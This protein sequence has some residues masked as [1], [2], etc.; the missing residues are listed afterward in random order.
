MQSGSLQ[1]LVEAFSKS[2]AVKVGV[3]GLC[4]DLADQP[5]SAMEHEVF[6]QG[7]SCYYY[8]E[9]TLFIAGSHPVVRVKP[10]IPLRYESHG[11]DFGWLMLRTDGRVVYRRCDPYTL[12]F[13]DV[14]KDC[15]IRWFVR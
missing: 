1:T 4:S 12:A 2:C 14:E 9:Q 13:E 15:A 10:D 7:G 5:S 3:R 6:V 8:T 11:W